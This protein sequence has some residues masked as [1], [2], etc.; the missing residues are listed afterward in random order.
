MLARW[1]T[2]LGTLASGPLETRMIGSLADFRVRVCTSNMLNSFP[3]SCISI[4]HVKYRIPMTSSLTNVREPAW[5]RV[6][7][8]RRG[9]LSR[10]VGLAEDE[11]AVL[12]MG[13]RLLPHIAIVVPDEV[14]AQ[15]A[16]LGPV[17]LKIELKGSGHKMSASIVSVF[18]GRTKTCSLQL[19]QC[20][21]I[22]RRAK[23]AFTCHYCGHKQ[24]KEHLCSCLDF[25]AIMSVLSCL[26]EPGHVVE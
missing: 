24:G 10:G 4:L 17:G 12:N 3:S 1:R 6:R 11:D 9:Q 21:L 16:S 26:P 20:L 8:A 15:R 13:R 19:M 18:P 7:T 25:L 2:A 5:Q 23:P 14:F 22:K